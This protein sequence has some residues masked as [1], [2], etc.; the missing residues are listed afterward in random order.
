MQG[1]SNVPTKA[2]KQN[3]IDDS[4]ALVTVTGSTVTEQRWEGKACCW[5]RKTQQRGLCEEYLYQ[6]QV[7]RLS[8]LSFSLVIS[9]PLNITSFSFPLNTRIYMAVRLLQC[10]I[11]GRNQTY[12]NKKYSNGIWYLN[13]L[14]TVYLCI[15]RHFNSL[16]YG[17]TACKIAYMKWNAFSGYFTLVVWQH[18]ATETNF[19]AS[20]CSDLLISLCNPHSFSSFLFSFL[21][22]PFIRAFVF[23]WHVKDF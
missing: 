8:S 18:K 19:Q 2:D 9:H 4:C 14:S 6:V 1:L 17:V 12:V 16:R 15:Y 23:L 10:F 20:D 5:R 3:G 11:K 13:F 22:F 21:K 7:S